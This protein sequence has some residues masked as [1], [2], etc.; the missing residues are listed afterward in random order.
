MTRLLSWSTKELRPRALLSLVLLL[1]TLGGVAA[2]LAHAVRELDTPLVLAV[3]VLGLL[4]GWILAIPALRGWVAL[5]LASVLGLVGIPLRVGRLGEKLGVLLQTSTSLAVEAFRRWLSERGSDDLPQTPPM[6]WE[7]ALLAL[8]N[9]R[10][11]VETLFDRLRAWGSAL[12]AGEPAFDPVVAA[13]V[14]SV[15]LWMVSAWAGWTAR[16]RA[17]PLQAVA[18]AGA[19]LLIAFYYKAEVPTLLAVILGVVLLLMAALTR[20]A[21]IQRWQKSEVEPIENSSRTTRVVVNLALVLVIVAATVPSISIERIV[22]FMRDMDKE[23]DAVDNLV[24]SLGV[25]RPPEPMPEEIAVFQQVR[26]TGLARS[27]LVGTGPELTDRRVMRIKTDDQLP[28]LEAREFAERSERGELPPVPRYYWRGLTYDLYVYFGWYTGDTEI[29]EY[30]AGEPAIAPTVTPAVTATA[31]L[32]LPQRTLQQD[33]RVI[34]DLQGIIHAAGTLVSVDQDYNVAWRTPYDAFAATTA[35]KTYRVESRLP[36]F[37][38]EQLQAAGADYPDWVRVNYLWLPDTV[39]ERVL[40]LAR[41][42]TADA[43]TPYDRAYVIEAYLREFPYNLDVPNPPTD[44]DVADYFLFEL[45]EGYCDYYA[46]AMVVLARAAG[47][48]ARYVAGYSTGDYDYTTGYYVVNEVN[49]HSWVDIYFPGYGWIEFEP[50]AGLPAIER[51]TEGELK[52]FEPPI[53]LP[54]PQQP[55]PPPW[56]NVE[57][58]PWWVTGMV[59]LVVLALAGWAWVAIDGW[60]LRRLKPAATATALYGRLRRQARRLAV[61]MRASDTPNEFAAAFAAWAANISQEEYWDEWLA[62]L[63]Q[64]VRYL[65]ECYVQAIYASRSLDDPEQQRAIQTWRKLGWHLWLTRVRRV[66]LFGRRVF[67]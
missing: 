66:R 4:T 67:D 23:G 39:P 36:V 54:Q 15:A 46:T 12:A 3:A 52:M 63:I 43:P 31:G 32:T 34:G 20:D 58:W 38:V 5:I 44:R 55:P 64:R 2:G 45:Q 21:R 25:D 28:I 9:L 47:L 59:G 51:P 27:H 6:D 42:L 60:R 57:N 62:A 10:T 40:A 37:T 33:I 18:P 19:L 13:L 24:E 53:D 65:V 48:P 14:W 50:T 7:P 11:G 8:E 29:T 1:A 35:E 16:R 22:E 56:W 49:A 26:I 17:R 41:D 30:R 61:P